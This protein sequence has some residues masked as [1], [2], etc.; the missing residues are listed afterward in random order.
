MF[1]SG[2]ASKDLFNHWTILIEAIYS[3]FIIHVHEIFEDNINKKICFGIAKLPMVICQPMG[4]E[5]IY[6]SVRKY[7]FTHY[8]QQQDLFP[9][10]YERSTRK[11][12]KTQEFE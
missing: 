7:L 3:I 9:L 8:A 4:E 11:G 12:M 6:G 10:Q 2:V 1:G 5:I